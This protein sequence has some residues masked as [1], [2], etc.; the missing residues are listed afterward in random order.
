VSAHRVVRA[1][2][3]DFASAASAAADVLEAGGLL[4]MPTDTVYGLGA[5]LQCPAA[6][7]DIYRAKSRPPDMPLPVLVASSADASRLA[8]EGLAQY[9]AMLERFWP[10]ALTVV[11]P[12]APEVPREVT[13]GLD[14]VGLRQPDSEVALEVLRAAGGALAVTSANLSG[15]SP[16]REVGELPAELLAH[17]DLVID[18]GPCPGGTASTVLDLTTAPPRILREGPISRDD[19]AES[20]GDIE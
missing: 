15:D 17:V 3:S 20:L 12:A 14:T 2:D 7:A 4:V 18:A 16:A 1:A 6:I 19:L 9:E 11:V 10:G 13:A 5:S 8:R